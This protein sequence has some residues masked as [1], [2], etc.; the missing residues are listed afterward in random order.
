MLRVVHPVMIDECL[1]RASEEGGPA[2]HRNT[3]GQ[4]DR[5]Q[6]EEIWTAADAVDR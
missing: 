5:T 6:V 4:L 2:L 1:A 3:M